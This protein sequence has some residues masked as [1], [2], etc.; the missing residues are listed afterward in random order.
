MYQGL[1]VALGAGLG[2]F[3]GHILGAGFGRFDAMTWLGRAF[4]SQTDLVR[5]LGPGDKVLSVK[6][7]CV[8]RWNENDR[9]GL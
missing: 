7:C 4:A 6:L 8:V 2:D 3:V 5:T 9:K 1:Q